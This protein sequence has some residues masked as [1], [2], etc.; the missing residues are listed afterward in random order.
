M[1]PY[2]SDTHT[3]TRLAA[4]N[5]VACQAR[6]G[7]ITQAQAVERLRALELPGVW[8]ATLDEAA[9]A[10]WEATEEEDRCCTP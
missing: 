8:I 9:R 10:L 3:L 1:N 5:T 2:D 7:E 4:L 6:D